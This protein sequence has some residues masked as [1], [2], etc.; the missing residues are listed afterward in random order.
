MKKDKEEDK[1]KSKRFK[2]SANEYIYQNIEK[3]WWA[4]H[5]KDKEFEVRSLK[6]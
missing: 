2:F 4:K 5:Y 1:K 6:D 3:Q